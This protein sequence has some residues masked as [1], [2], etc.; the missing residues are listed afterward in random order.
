MAKIEKGAVLTVANTRSGTGQKGDWCFFKA[1]GN[2]KITIWAENHN[3]KCKIG[4]MVEILEIKSVSSK[5]NKVGDKYYDNLSVSALLRNTGASPTADFE[6]LS[7]DLDS[8]DS[9]FI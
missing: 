5:T 8:D 2:K 6:G 7:S 9:D 3:F 4:D 1:E